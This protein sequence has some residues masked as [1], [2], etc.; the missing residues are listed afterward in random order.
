MI[1]YGERIISPDILE[2][3][4]IGIEIA[5]SITS[6]IIAEEIGIYIARNANFKVESL[7]D[8]NTKISL[9]LAVFDSELIESAKGNI[10]TLLQGNLTDGQRILLKLLYEKLSKNTF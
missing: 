8:G 6:D 5:K 2:A 4:G 9:S 3:K 7:E 1:L 10:D